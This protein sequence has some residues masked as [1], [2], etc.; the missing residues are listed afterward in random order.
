MP[1]AMTPGARRE[2]RRRP[3]FA[4]P[5][6]DRRPGQGL[7][8]DRNQS[9]FQSDDIPGQAGNDLEQG[10]QARRAGTGGQ[11]APFPRQ[12]DELGIFQA[13]RGQLSTLHRA[14]GDPVEADRQRPGQ[15]Q[16]VACCPAPDERQQDDQANHADIFHIPLP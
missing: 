6:D 3:P 7:A 2:D 15:V 4:V 10:P 1:G 14:A 5:A 13:K 16:P 11:V 9:L 8:V 12:A